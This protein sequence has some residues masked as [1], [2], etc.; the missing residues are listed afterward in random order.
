MS[1]ITPSCDSHVM[2]VNISYVPFLSHNIGAAIFKCIHSFLHSFISIC[3]I[4]V[5]PELNSVS[6]VGVGCGLS[7]SVVGVVPLCGCALFCA[8][9]GVTT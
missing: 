4:D 6:R 8:R 7:M 1:E 2:S 5:I 9:E 3:A